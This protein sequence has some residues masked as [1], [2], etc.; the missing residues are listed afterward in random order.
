MYIAIEAGMEL[1]KKENKKL[2]LSMYDL[3][4]LCPQS[5][6]FCFKGEICEK[7]LVS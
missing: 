7:M 3:K 6:Y 2:L 4:R 5:I 1:K